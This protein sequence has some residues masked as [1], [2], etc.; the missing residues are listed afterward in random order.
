M[1]ASLPK[2]AEVVTS[3][4]TQSVEEVKDVEVDKDLIEA[5]CDFDFP[6][7]QNSSPIRSSYNVIL[8]H[9]TS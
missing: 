5:V 3:M 4:A 6:P 1:I 2:S 8:S 7:A 9:T